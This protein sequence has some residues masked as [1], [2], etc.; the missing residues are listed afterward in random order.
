MTVWVSRV[1]E[2]RWKW[3]LES[4]LLGS[5]LKFGLPLD[6]GF[7]YFYLSRRGSV[8]T[9]FLVAY[10][11]ALTWLNLG[12]Y[13]IW[14]YD[15]RLMPRFFERA[16]DLVVDE[17]RVEALRQ[18][19]QR[20]FAHHHWLLVAPL[21]GILVALFVFTPEGLPGSGL[22]GRGDA[23]YW[24]SVAGVVWTAILGGIGFF[25]VIVTSLV[26]RTIA[27]EDIVVD[28]IHPDSL[29]GIGCVGTYAIGT[30]VLFSTGSLFLPAGFLVA[31]AP[32]TRGLVYTA[33]MAFSGF[34]LL[35][36]LYPTVKIHNKAKLAR[37]QILYSLWKRQKVLRASN[38]P[39]D[40]ALLERLQA[41]YGEYKGV[42]LYPFE[43]RIL[44]ELGTSVL[45]PLAFLILQVYVFN[46]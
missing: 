2:W 36:F 35:S 5:L 16:H 20:L 28:P 33:V 42:H 18:H 29:G 3:H 13:F 17:G 43:I 8:S 41:E 37:E 31:D 32:E 23:V 40:D 30:T 7:L 21:L 25:G 10:L 4:P 44:A 46:G 26:V 1:I 11:F 34:I 15:R 39:E 14:Y 6:A 24:L 38:R 27:K 45:L 19:Y 12:P 9:E 22:G